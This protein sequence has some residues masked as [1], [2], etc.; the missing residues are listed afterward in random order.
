MG[1]VSITPIRMLKN[2]KVDISLL[3]NIPRLEFGSRSLDNQFMSNFNTCYFDK[4]V[5]ERLI[6]EYKPNKSGIN[7]ELFPDLYKSAEKMAINKKL[8]QMKK[9]KRE[10]L[11][12]REMMIIK[13]ELLETSAKICMKPCRIQRLL[14]ENVISL[15]EIETLYD[16]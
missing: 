10:L 1:G 2:R 13:K 4:K 6:E 8:I 9:I 3:S 5:V 15:D 16:L 11:K 7:R 12:L 14:D